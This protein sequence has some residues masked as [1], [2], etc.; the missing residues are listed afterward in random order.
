MV[1]PLI[2]GS[3][4][5]DTPV[6]LAPMAGITDAPFRAQVRHFGAAL[7]CSEMVASIGFATHQA[8]VR[9]KAEIEATDGVAAVQIAGR[10][11]EP[12]V[13]AAK[14]AEA[15]GA[16]IIDLNFGCPAKKVTNGAA[17]AALMREPERA[18]KIVEETAR[19]VAVPVTVKMRLGWNADCLN[20]AALIKGA[21]EVGAQAATVH[22]RT[23]AQ[24]YKGA[25][26]WTAI[27]EV[28]A[29]APIPVIANGDI[30]SPAAARRALALS[31]AAGVMIGRG[32]QGAPWLLAQITAD[33]EGR[34]FT[35]PTPA[36]QLRLAV[37]H[38]EA[39][40]SRYGVALGLRA[41]RKHLS[42]RVLHAAAGAAWGDAAR[43]RLVRIDAPETAKKLLL[44][45]ADRLE[46]SEIIEIGSLAA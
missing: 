37:A 10:E 36:E 17:G 38:Y 22:G 12:I 34:P 19:A 26:D 35:P 21:A 1:Q 29:E 2:I 8:D 3:H 43:A 27:G 9:A 16:A 44:S 28:V 30:D 41:A 32:A 45:I 31:G 20:A 13:E 24:A 46:A 11:P 6:F 15:G 4:Q 40:L 18:L 5:F 23:R 25:A 14:A 7:V 33:L 42:W 39:M